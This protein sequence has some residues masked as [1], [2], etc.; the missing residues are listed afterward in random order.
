MTKDLIP[1][2]SPLTMSNTD[3]KLDPSAAKKTIPTISANTSFFENPK[4]VAYFDNPRDMTSTIEEAKS[5]AVTDK[6]DVAV[7]KGDG[8]TKRDQEATE[9]DAGASKPKEKVDS[10]TSKTKGGNLAVWEIVQQL[11]V[12]MSECYESPEE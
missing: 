5:E 4:V 9:N 2:K 10:P 1:I 7:G 8:A 3:I 11:R 6:N 12:S